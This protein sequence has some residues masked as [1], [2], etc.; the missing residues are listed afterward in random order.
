MDAPVYP[1]ASHF[2]QPLR[3]ARILNTK[4]TAIA[5]LQAIPAAWA[6]VLEESPSV[7]MLVNTPML[8]P[9]LGN[10]SFQSLVQFGAVKADALARI[11]ARLR[12]LGPVA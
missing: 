6:I 8:K 3:L 7:R 1:P 12:M 4:D 11:D 5:D 9:H 10:F 2:V